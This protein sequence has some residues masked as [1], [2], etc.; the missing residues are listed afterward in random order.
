MATTP[1]PFT[2]KSDP[3]TG[4]GA[5]YLATE[6]YTCP[7]GKN[8]K[9]QFTSW[10]HAN[11][12]NAQ[13]HGSYIVGSYIVDTDGNE[14]LHDSM[15]NFTTSAWPQLIIYP[16]DKSEY[17]AATNFYR[18]FSY[19]DNPNSDETFTSNTSTTM[20]FYN[21]EFY[22]TA[23]EKFKCYHRQ[24]ANYPYQCIWKGL[25]IEEDISS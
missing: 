20:G 17:G 9:I 3:Y 24:A 13:A 16:V 22:M 23:G 21:T 18:G 8:V 12:T 5:T 4:G 19:K 1:K 14:L 25:I 15:N 7:A 2:W 11:L 10:M 6:L